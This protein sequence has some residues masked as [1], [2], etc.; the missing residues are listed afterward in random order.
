MWV[1]HWVEVFIL[2]RTMLITIDSFAKPL[3]NAASSRV[4]GLIVH[5]SPMSEAFDLEKNTETLVSS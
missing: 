1:M 2:L 5:P 4:S 3:D